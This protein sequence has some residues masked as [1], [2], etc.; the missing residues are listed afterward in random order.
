MSVFLLVVAVGLLALPGVSLR[1]S[2]R[3]SP[4]RYVGAVA[5]SVMSGAV[6][7]EAALS[8]AAV[9]TILRAFGLTELASLCERVAGHLV[10]G[11]AVTGWAATGAAVALPIAM[12]L[13]VHRTARDRRVLWDYAGVLGRSIGHVDQAE[14]VVVDAARSLALALP[15]EPARVVVTAGLVQE[16]DE[17]EIRAVIEHE[18]AHIDLGHH[19]HRLVLAGLSRCFGW[20][21]PFQRSIQAW[22]FGLERAADERAA[23]ATPQDRTAVRNAIRKVATAPLPVSWAGL[24]FS[25][26]IL[27]E[28]RMR[29][30]AQAP[31]GSSFAA[32]AVWVGVV[33]AIALA[34]AVLVA[35]IGHTHHLAVVAPFCHL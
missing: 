8:L 26:S 32:A 21:P 7:I 19:G 33:S 12:A 34:G 18:R 35:W 6:F 29:M 27:T 15:G 5:L 17:R 10:P 3:I 4:Q 20:L 24:A 13:G 11:G 9:P 31:C 22:R 14:V 16:L 2:R 28:E 1:P 23:G 25:P 30:L